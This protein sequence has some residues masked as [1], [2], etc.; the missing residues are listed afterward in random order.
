MQ[1]PHAR[2]SV[3]NK[4]NGTWKM[5]KNLPSMKFA[6]HVSQ[7]RGHC[8]FNQNLSKQFST[9]LVNTNSIQ[10]CLGDGLLFRPA[11]IH[12]PILMQHSCVWMTKQPRWTHST[13]VPLS[14][15]PCM[16]RG[17]NAGSPPSHMKVTCPPLDPITAVVT[18]TRFKGP[19]QTCL[20]VSCVHQD[21]GL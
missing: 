2:C 3:G 13:T 16:R 8:D 7:A 5:W 12:L 4:T 10:S 11:P 18:G 1:L 6:L 19:I 20:Q 9:A 14:R 15:F 21:V 17:S